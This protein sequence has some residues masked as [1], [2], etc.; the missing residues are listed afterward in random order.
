MRPTDSLWL[1]PAEGGVIRVLTDGDGIKDFLLRYHREHPFWLSALFARQHKSPAA[2]SQLSN[3]EASI[4]Y[5]AKLN[6]GK[7]IIEIYCQ[8]LNSADDKK[9]GFLAV[10][11]NDLL[12]TVWAPS[13][14]I[15]PSRMLLDLQPR[16]PLRKRAI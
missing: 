1:L 11:W 4:R 5:H 6:A 3:R 15:R 9:C 8:R 7:S 12:G 10:R 14:H 13:K 2:P 16:P